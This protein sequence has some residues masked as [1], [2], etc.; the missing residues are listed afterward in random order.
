[1][2]GGVSLK[3]IKDF[4]ITIPPLAEQ[5]RIVTKLD[6]AF[7]EIDVLSAVQSRKLVAIDT[8][9]ESA[10][11][12]MLKQDREE[13]KLVELESLCESNRGI[14]YGVIK[15]GNE[16]EDGVPCLRTSNVKKRKI[17][18]NGMKR[19]AVELS[20]EYERTILKGGEVLVN[21]RGTLGGVSVVPSHMQGWNISREVAMVPIDI[22]KANPDYISLFISSP[23]SQAWLNGNTKGAAY[24]GINL[25]DL[26]KLPVALPSRDE[27]EKV[28][29]QFEELERQ[30]IKA[31]ANI[32]ETISELDNLKSAILAQEL[33]P[34]QSEVA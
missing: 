11:V 17:V 28:V 23:T 8:L 20:M 9:I 32:E 4:T 30:S 33:K 31:K 26:R 16:V 10:L 5:Q 13:K 27:Q 21:V 19:I 2:I 12:K 18:T 6:T 24:Q 3:K 29:R 22:R 14:T 34:A 25:S 1:M 7:A 15:L